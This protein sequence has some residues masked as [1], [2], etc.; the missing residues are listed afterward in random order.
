MKVVETARK[1]GVKFAL[2]DVSQLSFLKKNKIRGGRKK[3]SKNITTF[4]RVT[5]TSHIPTANF[6]ASIH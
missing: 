2:G 5:K 1:K 3:L 4:N 6:D